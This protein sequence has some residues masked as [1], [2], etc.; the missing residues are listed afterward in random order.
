MITARSNGK[1]RNK[2]PLKVLVCLVTLVAFLCNTAFYDAAWAA[3]SPAEL[4]GG[5]SDRA[6]GSGVLRSNL[7]VDNI[8]IPLRLGEIKDIFAGNNGKIIIH[9]QDAHCNY[10]A[11]KSIEGIIDHLTS[12][13][14]NVSAISL[15]GGVGS[16]DL[17]AFTSIENL[18]IRR[19]VSDYF[20]REGRVSG[21][22][23]FAINN[24]DRAGL[25]GIENEKLYM[26]NL[27]AY[28]DS[29]KYK[30][31]A[32]KNI[33][34]LSTAIEELK[35]K[36]Y[37]PEL[38]ELDAGIDSYKEKKIDFKEYIL[39]LQK[40]AARAKIDL[41]DYRGIASLIAVL[42]DEKSINFK[43]ADRERN[44]LIDKIS[45][46]LSKVDMREF[47]AKTLQF[48]SGDISSDAFYG[49]LFKKAR[50]SRVDFSALPNLVRY[51]EY[52][53]KYDAIDKNTVFEEIKKL[54]VSLIS[55]LAK[56]EDQKAL[57][58]LEKDLSI[59]KSM[60][61]ISLIKDEFDY[62]IKN[63]DNFNAKRFV[64]FI[65]KKAPLY[66][67][68][69]RLDSDI[70]QLDTYRE[71]MEKFYICSL[72]RDDAF[73]KNIG[74]KLK[75]DNKQVTILVTGG[76]HTGNISKL[77]KD[78]KYSYVEVM[79]KFENTDI[80][81]NYFKLLAGEKS[82]FEKSISSAISSLQIASLCNKLG[83]DVYGEES[84]DIFRIGAIALRSMYSAKE[85]SAFRLED[86]RFV[87]FE[88]DSG[89]PTCRISEDLGGAVL[90][91]EKPVA[92]NARGLI[93]AFHEIG[94]DRVIATAATREYLYGDNPIIIRVRDILASLKD[95]E[96]KLALLKALDSLLVRTSYIDE[97]GKSIS[98]E[99][100]SAIQIVEDIQS[101][102]AGG[103]G[104]Y[105]PKIHS[106]GKM[107][108]RQISD[109]AA[110]LIH[111][112]TAGAIAGTGELNSHALA[113]SVENAV[114]NGMIIEAGQLLAKADLHNGNRFI[115][116]MTAEERLAINRDYS[117]GRVIQSNMVDVFAVMDEIISEDEAEALYGV[118]QKDPKNNFIS[119]IRE[120][121]LKDPDIAALSNGRPNI[122][123]KVS[124]NSATIADISRDMA[125]FN[126]ARDQGTVTFYIREAFLELLMTQAPSEQNALLRL[127]VL[128]QTV[129]GRRNPE[130]SAFLEEVAKLH[131]LAGTTAA[132]IVERVGKTGGMVSLDGMA[133]TGK[134]TYASMLGKRIQ[135]L[136]Q[137]DVE[138]FTLSMFLFDRTT[139]GAIHKSVLGES[140]S[141][142]EKILLEDLIGK[143]LLPG[144]VIGKPWLGNEYIY[145]NT[146][147]EDFVRKLRTY[148]DWQD[149]SKEFAVVLHNVYEQSIGKTL[150]RKTITL[151]K[152]SAPGRK[153]IIIVED[154]YSN[155]ENI[156]DVFDV[157]IRMRIN[158]ETSKSRYFARSI[159]RSGEISEVDQRK[160]DA[161][162][163]PSYQS[164]EKRTKQ[165]ID[166]LV[167]F[168]DYSSMVASPPRAI[169]PELSEKS[170]ERAQG[171]KK[172]RGPPEA[173]AIRTARKAFGNPQPIRDLI[174]RQIRVPHMNT[175]EFSNR[176]TIYV[177]PTRFCPV[178][179]KFCYFA[180]PMGANK[181]R[182]N[183]FDEQGTERF[184]AFTKAANPAGIVVS[185]GGDPFVELDKVIKIVRE[186]RADKITLVTSGFWAK[187]PAKVKE[188][189]RKIFEASQQ[190]PNVPEVILRLS[191]DEYHQVRVP[192][193]SHANVIK[194]FSENYL[195]HEKFR[196][197][198]HSLRGDRELVKLEELLRIKYGLSVVSRGI[199]DL[200]N[201]EIVLDN[202]LHIKVRRVDIFNANQEIDLNDI[203][204]PQVD[205]N[206]R[207]FARKNTYKATRG[208]GR[209]M[210]GIQKN[211]NGEDAL[212]FLVNYDGL[213]EVWA[214]SM[215]DNRSNLYGETYDQFRQ[216]ALA[217]VITLA[218]LEK[219][220]QYLKDLVYE[221]NPIAMDRAVAINIPDWFS[222]LAFEESKTRLY[223]SLRILQDY[224]KEGRITRAEL[225]AWPEEL[226]ELVSLEA[227]QLRQ[228]YHESGYAI[229]DQYLERP[230]IRVQDLVNLYKSIRLNHYDVTT[231]EARETIIDSK[232]LTETQKL[233]FLIE[234]AK[235]NPE[236]QENIP[237]LLDALK[238]SGELNSGGD[239]KDY[240]SSVYSEAGRLL[241]EIAKINSQIFLLYVIINQ[242]K[243][244]ELSDLALDALSYLAR[245]DNEAAFQYLI[246][247]MEDNS[248]NWALTTH[249]AWI[250]LTLK[251]K[252]SLDA[253]KDAFTHAAT[254][255]SF[256]EKGTAFRAIS[257]ALIAIAQAEHL[258][259]PLEYTIVHS[260]HMGQEDIAM[261]ALYALENLADDGVK[262]AESSMQIVAH[263]LLEIGS[264]N[265]GESFNN[266]QWKVL[267]EIAN[268]FDRF[269]NVRAVDILEE[270]V[271]QTA[272]HLDDETMMTT[273]RNAAVA[274]LNIASYYKLGEFLVNLAY[275]CKIQEIADAA[276]KTYQ[277]YDIGSFNT[278]YVLPGLTS[279]LA[280]EP[281]PRLVMPYSRPGPQDFIYITEPSAKL[282]LVGSP[283]SIFDFMT[284][285]GNINRTISLLE[286]NMETRLSFDTVEKDMRLLRAAGLIERENRYG[287]VV[288]WINKDVSRDPRKLEAAKKILGR[289]FASGNITRNSSKSNRER[290]AKAIGNKMLS[291]GKSEPQ[292]GVNKQQ[293]EPSARLSVPRQALSLESILDSI[294]ERLASLPMPMAEKEDILINIIKQYKPNGIDLS[295]MI[296]MNRTSLS[297]FISELE[298][299]IKINGKKDTPIVV[300]VLGS[301]SGRKLF[302]QRQFARLHGLNVR[303][304]AFD[305]DNA[306]IEEA[307]KI[308]PNIQF[309][310]ADLTR[311]NEEDYVSE[312]KRQFNIS[313]IDVEQFLH[314]IYSFGPGLGRIDD[315][316]GRKL[317]KAVLEGAVKLLEPGGRI[318]LFDGVKPDQRGERVVVKLSD[319]YMRAFELFAGRE[320]VPGRYVLPVTYKVLD[321]KENII[322]LTRE[323][324]GQFIRGINSLI[325]QPGMD[326]ELYE[327]RIKGAMSEVY[328][329]FSAQDYQ[330]L[331]SGLGLNI[332]RTSQILERTKAASLRANV[333]IVSGHTDFPAEHIIFSLEKAGSGSRKANEMPARAIE[334]GKTAVYNAGPEMIS[335]GGKEYIENY[336]KEPMNE[337]G[338]L[339]KSAMYHDMFEGEPCYIYGLGAV[340]TDQNGMPLTTEQLNGSLSGVKS[341]A[342]SF[343][344]K[345]RLGNVN[346]IFGSGTEFAK[347]EIKKMLGLGIKENRI[348]CSISE[349]VLQALEK[350]SDFLKE[351]G[352]EAQAKGL[353]QLLMEKTKLLIAK[354]DMQVVDGKT[355]T[356]AFPFGRIG[357]E[358]LAKLNLEHFI[359]KEGAINVKDSLYLAVVSA[360]A[361]SIGLLT[362]N[363]RV[364]EEIIALATDKDKGPDFIAKTF[365]IM[366]P[367]IVKVDV[368][369]IVNS[370][371]AEAEVLRAL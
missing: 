17:S 308:N 193:L 274:I 323:A 92:L 142:E 27:N 188:I 32:D 303:F 163:R 145:R 186:A 222:R 215:P 325:R 290:I 341:A 189:L 265:E 7:A 30:A 134:T 94:Q 334:L 284:M 312:L 245:N 339:V 71:N 136:A 159:A 25:F 345:E 52:I 33:N 130:L 76:F 226:R 183:A 338:A 307:K 332:G 156:Q 1:L 16:Y 261:S 358:G 66:G 262:G 366:L 200:V 80:E 26:D 162:I 260:A 14:N 231:A 10:G 316:E 169:S 48:K 101:A 371:K 304:I 288:F 11:Q 153:R 229:V 81:C 286:L 273:Y 302:L 113:E 344:M 287:I 276:R 158:E 279:E 247:L 141:P 42:A 249:I 131:N 196:L 264:A 296:A 309:V 256:S 355:V 211:A 82:G 241:V 269:K 121:L 123:V 114:R 184:I 58:I 111:E 217:D 297:F 64:D 300:A 107:D 132:Q 5:G 151:A 60:L 342:N 38:K 224:L 348:R 354:N 13:Y 357:L 57:Y 112:L 176:P 213:V 195:G 115:W 160:Y 289:E 172:P 128:E 29:I 15:E 6:G 21:P 275:Y 254:E 171:V 317:V 35:N 327:A 278:A 315:A 291:I 253:L 53:K 119:M 365:E 301:G 362:N 23:S 3:G 155:R 310:K 69:F 205:A 46:K 88:N 277:T 118:R 91:S 313:V 20:V 361:K 263:G 157:K 223:V 120:I 56:N 340:P 202:G 103:Q 368:Q 78:Q 346:F 292:A 356:V 218:E 182:E 87:I 272:E 45:S 36:I 230:D 166:V 96:A 343:V 206:F 285:P 255:D 144:F 74:E 148:I 318:V 370:F 79:P 135:T 154:L 41:K 54:E 139:R 225:A 259:E 242:S 266:T 270:L 73:I 34:A 294:V 250:L 85:R 175:E 203:T 367:A 351:L 39:F 117:S 208:D 233:E 70:E 335:A 173:H 194:A 257:H 67:L 321:K 201:S 239:I 152:S 349:S 320:G 298:E 98:P 235:L 214:S 165:D 4:P 319:E 86:G 51:S 220:I 140:L 125:F 168:D 61:S 198:V 102:H 37:S 62:Y 191:I 268:A 330:E 326:N 352:P 110:T 281:G 122:E 219:G 322:E 90:F 187:N 18:D 221:V 336:V 180:S 337:V 360:W 28:R 108:S 12:T 143:G 127:L 170:R 9:I 133:G 282:A 280:N 83:V 243:T 164:Y 333:E 237:V 150:S 31:Q 238:L 248:D 197:M 47:V 106:G 267:G 100:Y 75:N 328:Q 369:D 209:I 364:V 305:N 283:A 324:F 116:D 246:H 24:P 240:A 212:D 311:L 293:A 44:A 8:E 84:A 179:C 161:F 63:R 227:D 251:R 19:K 138:N 359:Q 126:M 43:E 185:G 306:Y 363:N 59:I 329:F 210:M 68:A 104:I 181:T 216:K 331:F 2:K 105:L 199:G 174:L 236:S 109:Y 93:N 299:F 40:N 271:N 190:N 228:L 89:N 124:R 167:D 95:S 234:A 22:E 350:D 207:A 49:Y 177:F 178:G 353:R 137:C 192:L 258:V 252:D 129:K 204:R 72:K 50:F 55:A 147:I 295:N 232:K 146:E 99:G 97:T 347:A 244:V 65:N 77:F 314:E 149:G